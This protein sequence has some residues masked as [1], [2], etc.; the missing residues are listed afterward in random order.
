M[1]QNPETENVD[2][3][4]EFEIVHLVSICMAMKL[5]VFGFERRLEHLVQ[6]HKW[7]YGS[8]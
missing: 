7:I 6:G 4:C 2:C 5:C 1:H 8:Q 3:L